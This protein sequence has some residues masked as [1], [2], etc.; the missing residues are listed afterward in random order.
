MNDP[1]EF[2]HTDEK[3]VS[4]MSDKFNPKKAT[5]GDKFCKIA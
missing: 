3:I 1:F 5:G 4:K 2:K